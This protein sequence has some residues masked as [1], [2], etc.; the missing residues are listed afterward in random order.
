[1]RKKQCHSTLQRNMHNCTNC[2]KWVISEEVSNVKYSIL[3]ALAQNSS[4]KVSVVVYLNNNY[5]LI[6]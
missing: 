6:S 4:V 3:I 2:C 1:M 5:F